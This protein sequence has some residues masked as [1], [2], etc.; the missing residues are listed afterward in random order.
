MDGVPCLFDKRR[1]VRE[2]GTYPRC[3]GREQDQRQNNTRSGGSPRDTPTEDL[4][5]E[6]RF[7]AWLAP[8]AAG[9]SRLN[10]RR[11]AGTTAPIT[12]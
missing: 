2:C 11:F 4:V 10:T 6:R 1:T 5:R 8:V 12:G 7:R 3:P 9:S